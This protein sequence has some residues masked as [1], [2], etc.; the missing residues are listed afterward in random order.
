VTEAAAAEKLKAL[1]DARG[2]LLM[3]QRRVVD[4]ENRLT[5]VLHCTATSCLFDVVQV[6]SQLLRADGRWGVQQHQE[7][8]PGHDPGHA[9][10]HGAQQQQQQQ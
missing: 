3:A 4:Q 6:C 8:Q 9:S 7:R 1:R 5:C 2:S 10:A